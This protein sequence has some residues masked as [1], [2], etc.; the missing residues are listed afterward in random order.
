MLDASGRGGRQ[1]EFTLA[2]WAL[3]LAWAEWALMLGRSAS[4]LGQW[5]IVAGL[6]AM[7]AGSA[8]DPGNKSGRRILSAATHSYPPWAAN[9]TQRDPAFG[10]T[11]MPE[12]QHQLF[13][14][15]PP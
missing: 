10:R 12:F 2:P 14:H 4:E 1:S 13:G 9:E 5:G 8:T 3:V 11:P 6:I 7:G 15:H